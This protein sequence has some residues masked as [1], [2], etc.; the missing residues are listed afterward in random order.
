MMSLVLAFVAL[1]L[2][3]PQLAERTKNG[4]LPPTRTSKGRR[5]M[6]GARQARDGAV[7]ILMLDEAASRLIEKRKARFCGR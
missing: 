6:A 4:T 5:G 1:D 2:E 3:A 7:G